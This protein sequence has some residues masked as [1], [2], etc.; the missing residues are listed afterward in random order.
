MKKS[1]GTKKKAKTLGW[2]KKELWKVFSQYIRMRD[3]GVCITCGAIKHWKKMQAGHCIPKANG[4]LRLYF[5]ERNV[6]C[7]CYRCNIN[8]GGNGAVYNQRIRDIYGTTAME[9]LLKYFN[10]KDTNPLILK[11]PDYKAK[12]KKYKKKIQE[13]QCSQ[14]FL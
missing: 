9:T 14:S 8:L 4:G 12:I 2:Y 11:I 5:D 1:P 10:E 3:S 6:N 7:Q 13:L